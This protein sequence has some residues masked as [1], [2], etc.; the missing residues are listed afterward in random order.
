MQN[1]TTVSTPTK[2]GSF[3]SNSGKTSR[4]NTG[5]TSRPKGR[6]KYAKKARS[7]FKKAPVAAK[8]K[9]P[10]NTYTSV[11]C[12]VP[13]T[14]KACVAVSKKDA[15]TQTLGKFRCSACK[16]RCKVTVSK[17]K[18]PE[19]YTAASIKVL[20]GMPPAGSKVTF[21][22]TVEGDNLGRGTGFMPPEA[23][24]AS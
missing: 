5:S 8:P 20:E 1:S 23:V 19:E 15:L 16:K 14:K 21:G 3:R 11:C 17:Y 2:T 10:V 22:V 24:V 6:S 9:G 4:P 12:G 7:N 18:A 13:A